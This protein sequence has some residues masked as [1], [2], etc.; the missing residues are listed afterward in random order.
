MFIFD[1]KHIASAVLH[2]L[3]KKLTS[4]NAYKKGMADS[5]I[6]QQIN[7]F[8]FSNDQQDVTTYES[9]KKKHKPMEDQFI[10]P[11]DIY[12]IDGMN[13]KSDFSMKNDE[14]EIYLQLNIMDEYK[15][16]NPLPFWRDH[17]Q[18][19]PC[20]SLVARRLFS[21]Y[22]TSAAGRVVTARHSSLDPA[23]VNDI[24]DQKSEFFFSIRMIIECLHVQLRK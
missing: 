21:I 8:F 4:V 3:H 22:V 24:L 10:D 13:I 23:I 17:Q 16:H 15:Q 5:Y 7:G 9:S 14:L 6:R 2:L 20:L 1:E 12:T 18:K 19:F 11:G